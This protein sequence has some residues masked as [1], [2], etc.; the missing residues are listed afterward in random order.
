MIFKNN[1]SNSKMIASYGGAL[2]VFSLSLLLIIN[3]TEKLVRR[4]HASTKKIV[5]SRKL[6]SPTISKECYQRTNGA[7]TY[8]KH[9][10]EID[11]LADILDQQPTTD[12]NIFFHVTSCSR[13]GLVDLNTR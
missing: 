7:N 5:S 11:Y 8:H 6:H 3:Y 2:L 12:E 9:D 10:Y 4:R 1:F 13:T